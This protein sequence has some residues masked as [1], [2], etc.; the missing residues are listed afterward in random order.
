MPGKCCVAFLVWPSRQS[1]RTRK[2]AYDAEHR[3]LCPTGGRFPTSLCLTRDLPD[4]L[5]ICHISHDHPGDR[6]RSPVVMPE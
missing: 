5:K 1:R 3:I 4:W 2:D 6:P